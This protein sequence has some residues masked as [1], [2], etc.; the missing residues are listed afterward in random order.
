MDG[1]SLNIV[2]E[3]INKLKELFPEIVSEDKI[4]WERL[5]AEDT[6]NLSCN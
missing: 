4:D 2:Q 1:N 6:V 5:R 3:Q